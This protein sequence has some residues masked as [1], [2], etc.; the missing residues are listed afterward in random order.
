[1][2]EF[3]ENLASSLRNPL[4][5]IFLFVG[6]LGLCALLLTRCF[7][8]TAD[9]RRIWQA[10]Y[11]I[12][13]LFLFLEITGLGSLSRWISPFDS[14]TPSNSALAEEIE[15]W[16]ALPA[17]QP[18]NRPDFSEGEILP[19]ER[20]LLVSWALGTAVLWGRMALAHGLLLLLRS[21]LNPLK[22]PRLLQRIGAFASKIGIR[23]RLTVLASS[24][25]A[26]PLIFGWLRPTLI[27]PQSFTDLLER[28]QQDAVLVHELYHIRANDSFWSVFAEAVTAVAWWHPMVWWTE[29]SFSWEMETAADEA[30]LGLNEHGPLWLAEA[31][32]KLGADALRAA[33]P[34]ALAIAGSGGRSAL[35]KR[36]RNLLTLK[37]G[38]LSP[39]H[40]LYCAVLAPTFLAIVGIA[41][42]VGARPLVAKESAMFRSEGVAS[43]WRHSL[44]GSLMA[45]LAGPFSLPASSLPTDETLPPQGLA[46]RSIEPQEPQTDEP[47]ANVPGKSVELRRVQTTWI[48]LGA[49]TEEA[50]ADFACFTKEQKTAFAVLLKERE[51]RTKEFREL[52]GGAAEEGIK[53]NKWYNEEL[54]KLI[55]ARQYELYV[56]YWNEAKTPAARVMTPR[57]IALPSAKQAEEKEKKTPAPEAAPSKAPNFSSMEDN[58]LAQLDLSQ[59]Q[60]EEVAKARENLAKENQAYKEIVKKGDAN[61]IAKKAGEINKLARSSMQKIMTESQ[62]AKYLSLWNGALGIGASPANG[63]LAAPATP[64]AKTER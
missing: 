23:S 11:L 46:A 15:L 53:I 25:L 61:E 48:T 6:L 4:T 29:I 38:S 64:A 30:S 8:R 47:K 13:A 42:A 52:K 12:L 50:S 60:K 32:L 44:A 35:E 39:H 56:E 43:C 63:R 16:K 34:P 57:W 58:I 45:L 28:E 19:L 33:S 1:M 40:S 41:L 55:T 21:R 62:Y 5:M 14:Q 18:S 37:P 20:L 59:T 49:K 24:R 3:Y 22:D 36:V 2:F 54:K 26:S 7:A 10:H 9:R 27:I 17:A 51:K 31:I